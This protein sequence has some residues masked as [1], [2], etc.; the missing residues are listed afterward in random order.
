[1]ITHHDLFV[2]FRMSRIMTCDS[3]QI[4]HLH[5][6]RN[7]VIEM[8]HT[9]ECAQNAIQCARENNANATH[10]T[11]IEFFE[12]AN[13]YIDENIVTCVCEYEYASRIERELRA[14]YS[15]VVEFRIKTKYVREYDLY[16]VVYAYKYDS[17]DTSNFIESM[18]VKFDD[19]KHSMKLF[20][21]FVVVNEFSIDFD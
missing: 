17:F 16:N 10:T 2:T 9:I 11:T 8:M 6:K 21:T 12:I 5:N 15:N 1:M 13:M 7:D 19:T 3:L 20:E 14:L 4:N 18:I